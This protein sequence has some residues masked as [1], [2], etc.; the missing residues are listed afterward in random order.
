M[1]PG[2]GG[3]PKGVALLEKFKQQLGSRHCQ[4]K[5]TQ[6]DRFRLSWQAQSTSKITKSY[7]VIQGY[8]MESLS[9]S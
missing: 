4:V 3:E 1:A 7:L 8:N 5:V 2:T 9:S 6:T